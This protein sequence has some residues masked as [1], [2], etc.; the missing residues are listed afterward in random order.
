M[1]SRQDPYDPFD[2]ELPDDEPRA[3][4]PADSAAYGATSRTLPPPAASVSSELR[5]LLG[6]G[7]LGLV[8]AS[9]TGA[10]LMAM[11]APDAPAPAVV[12]AA[13]AEEPEAVPAASD[14][15]EVLWLEVPDAT[16]IVV[17]SISQATLLLE[18]ASPAK[19]PESTPEPIVDLDDA[20]AEDDGIIDLD[21][22]DDPELSD[23][24]SDEGDD[25]PRYATTA[26]PSWSSLVGS[27]SDG[28]TKKKRK[29]R[30]KKKKRKVAVEEAPADEPAS[31]AASEAPAG[32]GAFDR[33]TATS[34]MF[35]AASGASGCAVSGGPKGKGR[36]SVTIAPGGSV[37]SVNVSAPFG[38]TKVG[39]CVAS[40]FRGIS[41]A[42][43]TGG[44]VA[45]NKSF[46]IAGAKEADDDDDDEAD[47]P[48]AT[49]TDDAPKKKRKKKKKKK[50][51]KRKKK[52]K[53][54]RGRKR[55]R[56]D[57]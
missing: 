36:V 17:E 14:E 1:P 18:H 37:S 55:G 10:T 11:S 15:P 22:P 47:S 6:A 50:R 44:A 9:A 7:M 40:M 51:K 35:A 46:F 30:K 38:G 25:A 28:E 8:L 34:A 29:K 31:A 13:P 5:L 19:E 42:P 39:S 49:S 16:T 26:S 56:V 43:F 21:M 52:K 53:K 20:A 4:R 3:A 33:D 32:S 48:R 57:L 23:E 27:S 45:L 24:L 41:V 12:A 54:K 2:L